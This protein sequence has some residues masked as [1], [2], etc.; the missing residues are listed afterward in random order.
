MPPVADARP[1]VSLTIPLATD[2]DPSL[3][4]LCFDSIAAQTYGPIE[5]IVFL[6]DGASEDLERAVREFG[7]TRLIRG[8]VSKTAARNQLAAQITGVYML[9]LDH[10]MELSPGLIEDCVKLALD[11]NSDAVVTA[12]L[13][14]P[15]RN[16]WRRCRA[17][18]WRLLESDIGAGS[19]YFV[20]AAVF[21]RVGGFDESIDM[22]DDWVLTLRIMAAGIPIDKVDS[23]IL[24]RDATN[25][26]EMFVR[27]YRRG[28][29]LPAL[30]RRFPHAPQAR[31]GKR[32]RGI[33]LSNLF[34]LAR[35]PILAAG[36]AFIKIID[37]LGLALGRLRPIAPVDTDGTRRYFQAGTAGTYDEIRLG[38]SFNRFKHYSELRAL[39][40]LLNST[41]GDV[42]EVG[43][44][45]GRITGELKRAGFRVTPVDPSAAMLLEFSRKP[46]LP[47]PVL[48]DGRSLPFRKLS[49][50]GAVSLR[51]VWH[52]PSEDGVKR[53]LWEMAR[54]S[55][56]FVIIDMSNA[57]R[58][59]SPIFRL[60]T[61]AH[62][63]FNPAERRH[64][65]TSQTMKLD[66]F[67]G[68][69]ESC[70]LRYERKHALDVL[71]PIWLRLLPARLASRLG[72]ALSRFESVLAKVVSPGRYLIRFGKRLEA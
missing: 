28:R 39:R 11:R 71:T 33:Y 3:V 13:E 68:L 27:K 25:L 30:L 57:A 54:V 44:G 24:I 61:A 47:L 70:G 34:I 2:A 19:P 17:L 9:Y 52:L 45:T 69:A 35:S 63:L 50:N 18:E 49:F 8:W 67:I 40:L 26:G 16:F 32:F 46:S 56:D 6:S 23:P 29:Y 64:H 55:S 36:L 1:L 12:Q 59:R 58:W 7:P 5:T 43:A 21:D 42:I 62:F 65:S 51:V 38:N 31:F 22:W 41:G 37:A 14:A 10:D 4:A 20:S 53:M 66:E 48:A 72:P 60:L 15:S